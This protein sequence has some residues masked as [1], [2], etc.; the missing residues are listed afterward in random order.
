MKGVSTDLAVSRGVS[1]RL[2]PCSVA[3]EDQSASEQRFSVK[4]GT[5]R[6]PEVLNNTVV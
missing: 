4:R 5:D 6:W 3:N 2:H 1:G